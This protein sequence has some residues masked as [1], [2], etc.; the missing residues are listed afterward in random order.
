MAA[1]IFDESKK[2]KFNH[3]LNKLEDEF[4]WC[5]QHPNDVSDIELEQLK[6]ALEDLTPYA[7]N[8]GGKL[9]NDFK[10]FKKQFDHSANHPNEVKPGDYQKFDEM[11]QK[12]FKD[13][14]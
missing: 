3:L 10:N 13:L 8:I 5:A 7:K 1:P 9:F 11:I 12:L 6:Q 14:K 4:R 2:E